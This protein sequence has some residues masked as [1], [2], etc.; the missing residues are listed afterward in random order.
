MGWSLFPPSSSSPVKDPARISSLPRRPNGPAIQYAEAP[1]FSSKSERITGALKAILRSLVVTDRNLYRP[2]Q[3]VKMHGIVRVEKKGVLA[4]PA[5][6]EATWKVQTDGGDPV[7]DGKVTLSAHGTWEAEWPVPTSLATGAYRISCD[8]G[9]ADEGRISFRRPI[10]GSRN[11][12]C[13]FS[14]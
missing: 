6:K 14:P 3:T 5:F 4:T 1:E 13:R 8:A 12:G 2:G 9:G 11:I 7:T 10:C